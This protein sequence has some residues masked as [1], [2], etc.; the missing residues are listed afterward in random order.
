MRDWQHAVRGIACAGFVLLLSGCGAGGRAPGT[1]EGPTREAAAPSQARE[2]VAP[3]TGEG[4]GGLSPTEEITLYRGADRDSRIESES[5][6]EGVLQIYTTMR[7]EDFQKVQAAFTEAT[8]IPVEVWRA[9]DSE[10]RIRILKERDAGTVIADAVYDL[11]SPEAAIL[12]KEKVLARFWSPAADAYPAGLKDP[13]GHW[14]GDK[15][16]YL[17]AAYNTKALSEAEAPKTYEELLD[18]KWKGRFGIEQ[19]DMDWM[20]T[21]IKR[22]WGEEKG[23]EFFRRLSAQEPLTH[24]GHSGLTNLVAAGDLPLAITIFSYFPEQ[25][26]RQ[27]VP[28]EWYNLEPVV[29]RPYVFGILEGAR[30]PHAALRFAD[31]VLGREGQAIIA[32]ELASVPAHPEVPTDPERLSKGFD[33]I[34][35]DTTIFTEEYDRWWRLWDDLILGGKGAAQ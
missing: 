22:H 15:L 24:K 16:N 23:I 8:G 11:G 6:R 1:A 17:V 29:V 25:L 31:F 21:L 20:A 2:A 28:I 13:D 3:P 5:A 4:G 34:P 9:G 33:Y 30:H 10:V 19:T 12:V 35:V 32:E 26:K 14:V 18:P 7:V 27:G